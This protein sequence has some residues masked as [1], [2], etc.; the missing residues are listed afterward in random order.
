MKSHRVVYVATRWEI[1]QYARKLF[2]FVE[3]CQFSIKLEVK[4]RMFYTFE[5]IF[6]LFVHSCLHNHGRMKFEIFRDNSLIL[7]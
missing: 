6:G 4:I 3:N 5:S 7:S 1:P 2:V